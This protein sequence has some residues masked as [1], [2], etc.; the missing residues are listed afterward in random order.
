MKNKLPVFGIVTVILI[1]FRILLNNNSQLIFVVALINLIAL[2]VVIFSISGQAQAK[3]TERIEQS[4]VPKD[5]KMRE[6]RIFCQTVDCWA[7]IP[8]TIFYIIYLVCLC[9]ELGNDIISIVAL[10]L[11]LSDSFI[12]DTVANL[13]VKE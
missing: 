5:I 1:V 4:G 9:S 7:Y 10:G 2:L 11:S 12:A 6:K 8:L 3:I 13:C